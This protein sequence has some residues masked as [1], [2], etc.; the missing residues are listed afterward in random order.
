[1]FMLYRLCDPEFN[2]PKQVFE[3]E[4]KFEILHGWGAGEGVD[5]NSE[6]NLLYNMKKITIDET[7]INNNFGQNF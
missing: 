7:F 2:V 4:I 5:L 1:M 6:L 3:N